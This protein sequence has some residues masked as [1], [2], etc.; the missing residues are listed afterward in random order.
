LKERLI[1]EGQVI[2]VLSRD[3]TIMELDQNNP[4]IGTVDTQNLAS[5]TV[6]VINKQ[7]LKTGPK[8]ACF[9]SLT[10]G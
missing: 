2:D 8:T 3:D 6:T 9:F 10:V 7:A 5:G 4:W 1:H